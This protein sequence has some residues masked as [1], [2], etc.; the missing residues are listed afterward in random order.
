MG[1]QKGNENVGVGRGGSQGQEGS[2]RG[3]LGCSQGLAMVTVDC[4]RIK[5]AELCHHLLSQ[6]QAM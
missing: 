3:K 5:C 4:V 1:K 6:L 2:R